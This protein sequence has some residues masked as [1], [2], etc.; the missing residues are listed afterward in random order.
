MRKSFAGLATTMALV[1][2]VTIATPSMAA[3]KSGGSCTK[4]NATTRIGGDRYVCTK[5]PIVK[6][7]KLTWVW[8]QC[9]TAN[10]DY[11]NAQKA[12]ND[13]LAK[14]TT[15]L[16]KIDA[17]IAKYT[18][19]IAVNEAKAVAAETKAKDLQ[20]KA[21]AKGVTIVD[22]AFKADIR[23]VM[24]TAT[25]EAKA[26]ITATE[27]IALASQWKTTVDKVAPMIQWL[28]ADDLLIQADDFRAAGKTVDS[29]KAQ[30]AK[31]VNFQTTMKNSATTSLQSTKSTRDQAC[32]PGL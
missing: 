25:G 15:E 32:K 16:A 28:S 17:D 8:D 4:A 21:A 18:A 19:Q 13:S 2:S 22:K 3:N 26:T 6:N 14:A 20:A 24:T 27:V 29:L 5:N 12:L 1:A 31:T 7:A 23:R 10:N 9:I 30:R 11:L